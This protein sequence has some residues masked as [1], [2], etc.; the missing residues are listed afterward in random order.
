MA[1]KYPKLGVKPSS[2]PQSVLRAEAHERRVSAM[3]IKMKKKDAKKSRVFEKY[4]RMKIPTLAGMRMAIKTTV[5]SNMQ[6]GLGSLHS[7]GLPTWNDVLPGAV[8]TTPNAKGSSAAVP[9]KSKGAM[10]KAQNAMLE[11]RQKAIDK[12][13]KR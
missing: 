9:A 4:T 5:D 2:S 10:A 1:Q 11:S 3:E 12:E 6:Q 13:E 7:T 8:A